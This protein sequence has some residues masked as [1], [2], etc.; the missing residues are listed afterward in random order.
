MT[1]WGTLGCNYRAQFYQL[2]G[3]LGCLG[4]VKYPRIYLLCN[5]ASSSSR[6]PFTGGIVELRGDSTAF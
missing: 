2:V 4:V 6:H 5:H 1:K 3:L